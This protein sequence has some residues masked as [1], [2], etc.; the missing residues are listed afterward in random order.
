MVLE[1]DAGFI[2]GFDSE[3]EK[4]FNELPENWDALWLGGTVFK[5]APYSPRLK[6]LHAGTGL[7]GVI[8]RETIYDKLIE[9][10]SKEDELADIGIMKRVMPFTNCFRTSTNLV[11]H[12]AGMSTI[13]KRYVDYPELRT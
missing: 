12:K 11:I 10:L 9:S 4:A 6:R 8:F 7:Y 1:D 13:Q 5:S 3:L 2:E